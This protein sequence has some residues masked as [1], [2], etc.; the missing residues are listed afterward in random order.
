MQLMKER[1]QSFKTNA[2]KDVNIEHQRSENLLS[3]GQ[4]KTGSK[5]SSTGR[6]LIDKKNCGETSS[7]RFY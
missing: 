1:L 4:P 6:I 3:F 2:R 7:V 5:E